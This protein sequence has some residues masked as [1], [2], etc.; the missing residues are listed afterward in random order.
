MSSTLTQPTKSR[1]IYLD[2]NATTPVWPEVAAAMLPFLNE[3]FGNPASATHSYGWAAKLAIDKA[4]SQVARLIGATP[5]E[6]IFTSGA[7]E[8]NNLAILGTVLRYREQTPHV[9]TSN[10]EHKAVLDVCRQAETLFGAELTIIPADRFG[11]VSLKAVQQATRPNTRLVSLMTANNEVGTLN[12]IA[13]IGAWTQ[14]RGILLHTDAAQAC[15][16][17]PL[18]VNQ[19]KIDL[20]S[21][22]AH[23]FYG[24]KGVGALFVRQQNPT[25][26]LVPLLAGGSQEKGLRPGTLNVPGIIGLGA[27]CALAQQDLDLEIARL[28]Q[29]RDR[30]IQEVTRQIPSAILNGHP[31][32]RSCHNVS[33]S[34][35]D[36]ATDLFSLGLG[37]LALSTGS[38]CTTG[39]PNPSHVLKAI[40][41]CDALARST[42]RVGLSRLTTENDITIL[43][44]SLLDLDRKNREMRT[45]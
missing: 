34:F 43:I 20:L 13:E 25:V 44:K 14:P 35:S 15:G 18:E 27:A 28:T 4:R 11:Q 21:I 19:A 7:T 42:V 8:S 41:H 24:P 39:S 40:G 3:E 9:I 29:L 37:G 31:T 10:V 23:K 26:E 17:L 33:F 36:L 30:L 38:A 5:S 2:S 12:P 1:P 32:A 45:S 6:I 22:S 16:K